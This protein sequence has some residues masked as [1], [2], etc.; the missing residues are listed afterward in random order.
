[1]ACVV[2]QAGAMPVADIAA[3]LQ[4]PAKETRE[5]HLTPASGARC[6]CPCVRCRVASPTRRF[7]HA[8][9]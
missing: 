4:L 9:P 3:E 6:A 7:C 8:L 2:V 5:W 1:M